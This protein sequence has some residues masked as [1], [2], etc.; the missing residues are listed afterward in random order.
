MSTRP[1]GQIISSLL[2]VI[3]LMS[4]AATFTVVI[5]VAAAVVGATD[6]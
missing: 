6:S 5:V 2:S 1:R 4:A 3:H